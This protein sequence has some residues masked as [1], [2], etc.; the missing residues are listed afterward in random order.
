[1]AFKVLKI[2]NQKLWG[3]KGE[4]PRNRKEIYRYKQAL[5]IFGEIAKAVEIKNLIWYNI[6]NDS[7]F[8]F[9]R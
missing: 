9:K 7:I 2:K 1:M 3:E 4:Y 6:N 5:K 8:R